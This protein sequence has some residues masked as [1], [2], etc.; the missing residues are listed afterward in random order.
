MS[1]NKCV[2]RLTIENSTIPKALRRSGH[3]THQ[4][5]TL[6][7]VGFR[8]WKGAFAPAVG[9]TTLRRKPKAPTRRT[10]VAITVFETRTQRCPRVTEPR[11]PRIGNRLSPRRPPGNLQAFVLLSSA[12]VAAPYGRDRTSPLRRSATVGKGSLTTTCEKGLCGRCTSKT[13]PTRTRLA[14]CA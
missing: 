11:V 14:M 1:N 7:Q 9:S 10:T 13:L 12:S 2:L 4:P 8:W 6:C 5:R 3:P